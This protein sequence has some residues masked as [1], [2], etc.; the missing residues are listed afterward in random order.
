MQAVPPPR[1]SWANWPARSEDVDAQAYFHSR[2]ELQ[3]G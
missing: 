3:E 2:A 1:A